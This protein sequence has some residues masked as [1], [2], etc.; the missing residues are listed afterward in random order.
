MAI[1]SSSSTSILA[2]IAAVLS[3]PLEAGEMTITDSSSK[4]ILVPVTAILSCPAEAREMATRSSKITSKVVPVAAI[5]SQPLQSLQLSILSCSSACFKTNIT[6]PVMFL[7][8]NGRI[9]FLM[10]PVHD[11]NTAVSCRIEPE[12]NKLVFPGTFIF[13]VFLRTGNRRCGAFTSCD[14]FEM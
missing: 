7:R 10:R 6:P 11:F 9:S 2:P 14:L 8:P 4:S 13:K 1:K 5:R 3:R 12:E